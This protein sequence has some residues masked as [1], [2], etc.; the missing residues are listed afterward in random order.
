MTAPQYLC[1]ILMTIT[2]STLMGGGNN[3]WATDTSSIT[4]EEFKDVLKAGNVDAVLAS[5]KKI[6][7]MKY[8]Y[9]ILKFLDDLWKERR[10]HHPDLPWSLVRMDI[11][12]INIANLLLQADV[13]Q[14]YDGDHAELGRF[15]LDRISS[16]DK[17][18]AIEAISA[19]LFIDDELAVEKLLSVARRQESEFLFRASVVILAQMCTSSAIPSLIQLEKEVDD[20]ELR[21]FVLEEIQAE[22]DNIG[23]SSWCRFKSQ[24]KH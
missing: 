23:K 11:I 18:V 7:H 15:I 20:S 12:K 24:Q 13:N 14:I 4:K 19:S 6:H 5:L 10:Q 1:A 9:D 3:L 17:E 16:Q 21:S 8:K 22:K 2:L